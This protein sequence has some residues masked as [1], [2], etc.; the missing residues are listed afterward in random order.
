MITTRQIEQLLSS[1]ARQN[2]LDIQLDDGLIER[3]SQPNQPARSAHFKDR[4]LAA[5]RQAQ[6]RRQKIRP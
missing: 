1:M 6:K 5:M 3:L 2:L 4:A